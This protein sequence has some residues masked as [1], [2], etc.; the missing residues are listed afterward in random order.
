MG[1]ANRTRIIGGEGNEVW[2]VSTLAGDEL[3]VRVSHI[4]TFAAEQWAAEHARSAGAPVPEVLLV[5]DAVP[6]DGKTVAVWIH[7]TIPGR[8]L[9][10]LT[11]APAARRLTAEAGAMAHANP[12]RAD[13]RVWLA[14]R[15]RTGSTRRLFGRAG[16]GRAGGRGGARERNHTKPTLTRRRG[17]SSANRQVWTSPHLLHGDWLPEHVLVDDSSVTGIIDFGGARSGDPAYDFAYWQFFW[18]FELV[19]RAGAAVSG[20]GFDRGLSPR[21]RSRPA[22]RAA[23][24]VVSPR[25]QRAHIVAVC[26]G[27]PQL[28]GTALRAALCRGPAVL[29]QEIHHSRTQRHRDS[30]ILCAL[31]VLCGEFLF[32]PTGTTCIIGSCERRLF[33]CR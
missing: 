28:R 13:R 24:R 2:A 17:I 30:L 31:C 14:R 27:R 20:G 23:R 8:P 19:L 22:A 21:G 29:R 6:V 9:G 11:D 12:Q 10:R 26:T 18:D 5:D 32:G 16:L 33:S 1:I 3:M 15:M 25:H 7:R 4:D